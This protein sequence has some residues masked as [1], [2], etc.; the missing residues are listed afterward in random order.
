MLYKLPRS[1]YPNLRNLKSKT[2]M[3]NKRDSFQLQLLFQH[4]ITNYI[5][6]PQKL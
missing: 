3:L 5:Q 1:I 6:L 4:L 2:R